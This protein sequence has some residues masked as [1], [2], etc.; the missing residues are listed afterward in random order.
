M[1]MI[2]GANNPMNTR[3]SQRIAQAAGRK[4][5][6]LPWPARL[7]LAAVWYVS[8]WPASDPAAKPSFAATLCPK[9]SRARE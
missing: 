9:K 4:A 6:A 5:S 1:P 3:M 7:L 2:A 8:K